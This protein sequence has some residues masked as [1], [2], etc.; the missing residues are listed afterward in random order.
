MQY[1]GLRFVFTCFNFKCI[2]VILKKIN[3]DDI[4][5]IKFLCCLTRTSAFAHS[6]AL[7]HIASISKGTRWGRGAD[8]SQSY[9]GISWHANT[10][11]NTTLA[12]PPGVLRA[13]FFDELDL[14]GTNSLKAVSIRTLYTVPFIHVYKFIFVALKYTSGHFW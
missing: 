10:Y 8:L 7:R 1:V 4:C 13:C 12:P 11:Y 6:N 3:I 9:L 5:S 2:N 14:Y